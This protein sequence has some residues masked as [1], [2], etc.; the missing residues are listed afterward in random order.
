MHTYRHTSG[1][2]NMRDARKKKPGLG[3]DERER[4][5]IYNNNYIKVIVILVGNLKFKT[6]THIHR[7]K[8]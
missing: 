3:N 8:N 5:S 2:K 1:Y 4:K 7:E 6:K